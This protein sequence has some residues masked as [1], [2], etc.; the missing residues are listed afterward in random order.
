MPEGAEVKI[1]TTQLSKYIGRDVLN[2][3]LIGGRYQNQKPVGFNLLEKYLPSSITTIECKGKFIY[4]K[5]GSGLILWNTLG[6][7]GSWDLG[8]SSH[9]ALEVNF[10]NMSAIYFNDPRRFGTVKFTNSELELTNKLNSLGPDMLNDPP[11]VD[12]FCQKLNKSTNIT[13]LLM[14][15]KVI[16]GVGNYIKAE[17]LYSA[18]ISP[19]RVGNSLSK[20]EYQDLYE[21]I[22]KVLKKSYSLGGATLAT[23]HDLNGESG[24]FDKQLIIYRKEKDPLGNPIIKEL[25][26]DGRSTWWCPTVQC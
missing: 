1:I 13:K 11:G 6:M 2:I 15:Q 8:P 23:Y 22:I 3:R 24:K 26:P 14:N 19:W 7:T 10:R 25:T 9:P 5:F 21:S 4:W 17:A 12:L 20:N 16:S 18:K